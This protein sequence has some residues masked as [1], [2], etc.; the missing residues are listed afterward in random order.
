MSRRVFSLLLLC[1]IAA[2]G[3][4]P[5]WEHGFYRGKIVSFRVVDGQAIYQGDII[6]GKAEVLIRALADAQAG[7]KSDGR[8]EALFV[9]DQ[10]TYWPKATIPYAIDP[11]IK[12]TTFIQAAIQH[13]QDKT[14]VR[15][16]PHAKEADWVTFKPSSDNSVCA[17]SS[18]GVAGGEQFIFG[19]ELCPT[20]ALI[21]EI[22]HAVGLEHE[23]A[24]SDASGHIR[25][26]FENIQK[27]GSGQFGTFST[28]PVDV[29]DYDYSSIMHYAATDFS[30]NGQLAIETIPPGIPIGQTE[31][32]SAGDLDAVGRLYG[33]T[34][35]VT[36]ATNPAG[37]RVIVDGETVQTPI[38]YS[39][40][41]GS[42]HTLDVEAAQSDADARYVFGRWSNDG[43]QQQTVQTTANTSLFVANMIRFVRIQPE[44]S[45]AGAGTVTIVP[46]SED[47]YYREASLITGTFSANPGFYLSSVTS[48]FL[49]RNGYTNLTSE[50]FKGVVDER[51]Q[52]LKLTFSEKPPVIFRSTANSAA[53]LIDG[54]R[55]F[56]PAGFQWEP[57]STHTVEADASFPE[58]GGATMRV[59]DK[60][61]DDGDRAHSVTAGTEAVTYTASFKTKHLLDVF[62][63]P[64]TAGNV[65]LSPDSADGFF[66]AGSTVQVTGIPA[67]GYKFAAYTLDMTGPGNGQSIT[68]DDYNQVAVMFTRPGTIGQFSVMNAATLQPAYLAPGGAVTI[69]SP[70]FGPDA[71]V[72]AQAG[73]DGKFSTT[74]SNTRVL[75]NGVPAPLLSVS[76]NQTTIVAPYNI[77]LQFTQVPL[78]VEFKGQR[79]SAIRVYTDYFDPGI[80]TISGNGKGQAKA[81]NEDGSVN[82]A[83]NPAAKG[84]VV[85]IS[86][87][88]L[89]TTTP[90]LVDGQVGRLPLLPVDG[91][92]E[93]RIG[94]KQAEVLFAGNVEGQVSGISQVKARIPSDAPSGAAVTLMLL[95]EGYGNQYEATIAVK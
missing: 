76:K 8:K 68:V 82:S 35:G 81:L 80:Y 48:P 89:G 43:T 6:L 11:S 51:R 92:V 9:S 75:T 65:A 87:T 36:L 40:A 58:N 64:A 86:A 33:T 47:G 84:S 54:K 59:F 38:K 20:G 90:D 55:Y 57:G 31:A 28:Q 34:N 19:S 1:A 42:T 15:F 39:W 4:A 95:V 77:P 7:A 12:N 67:T 72:D 10:T 78:Q 14:P 18:L 50:G 32:L 53:L 2:F 69:Y 37:L 71:A 26:L 91:R 30:K 44:I 60:W 27:S 16:V 70:E 17:S 41:V 23:Q 24:R 94:S 73:A 61:S 62:A 79:T 29:G 13:W 22:G 46:A 56:T 25:I 66:E 21:H 45:P 52:G 93:L 5:R 88:G 74:L 63:Y 49:E 83:G 85:T 3:A